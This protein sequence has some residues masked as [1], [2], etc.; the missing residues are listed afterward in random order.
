M[1]WLNQNTILDIHCNF[2]MEQL[3]NSMN[4]N[5][6]VGSSSCVETFPAHWFVASTSRHDTRMRLWR[7][8]CHTQC[9][10]HGLESFW[11][12]MYNAR[13]T[14]TPFSTSACLM[15]ANGDNTNRDRPNSYNWWFVIIW[16]GNLRQC[17]LWLSI[18][19]TTSKYTTTFCARHME[20]W[21]IYH[22]KCTRPPHTKLF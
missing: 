20:G 1:Q 16:C 22:W 13:Q 7:S 17:V 12:T 5:Q 8:T 11:T 14:D 21:E 4:H 15:Y 19:F 2:T 9:P 18:V 10:L 6:L 3:V